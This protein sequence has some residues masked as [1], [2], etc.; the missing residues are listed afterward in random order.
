M[1]AV[2]PVLSRHRLPASYRL[3]LVAAW[4]APTALLL[5]ALLAGGAAPTNLL[6]MRLLLPLAILLMP[7]VYI[8]QEG[9]DVLPD[10]IIRR[11][12][13]PH[14][15]PYQT[16]ERWSLATCPGGC[17][18]I[19]WERRGRKALECPAAHLSHLPELLAALDANLSWP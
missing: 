8:W 3:L 17:V 14:Y 11:I 13:W 2:G 9:V 7:A 1:N 19:I 18:L 10:G 4:A 16:L 5:L 12:H 15:Y 6:D